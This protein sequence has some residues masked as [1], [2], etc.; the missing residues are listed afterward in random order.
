MQTIFFSY[1]EE[2]IEE[3]KK[4]VPCCQSTNTNLDSL[5]Q[6]QR[7]TK[8][9]WGK[10]HRNSSNE[11]WRTYLWANK[12]CIEC[13]RQNSK[14]GHFSNNYRR[15]A[16]VMSQASDQSFCNVPWETSFDQTVRAFSKNAVVLSIRNPFGCDRSTGKN[17][18][19]TTRALPNQENA[20]RHEETADTSISCHSTR[21]QLNMTDRLRDKT[22]GI[23][24]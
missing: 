8:L 1:V 5:K 3:R 4:T 9:F 20:V 18:R 10:Y 12:Y 23:Y 11:T 21:S 2:F 22:S 14:V 19:G 13:H 16:H 7:S 24:D 15:I 17:T 6:F